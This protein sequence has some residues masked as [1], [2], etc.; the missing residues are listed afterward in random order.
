MPSNGASSLAT[1]ETNEIV[2]LAVGDIE[3]KIEINQF[4]TD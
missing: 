2:Y 1:Y 3:G 4:S